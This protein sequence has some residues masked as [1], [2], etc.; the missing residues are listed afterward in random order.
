MAPEQIR[1]ASHVDARVDIWSLGVVLFELITGKL[2]FEGESAPALL[3]AISADAPIPVRRFRPEASRA[4][5]RFIASCLER[6]PSRRPSDIE[7]FAEQ[8]A[9]LRDEPTAGSRP[10]SLVWAAL[11]VGV[12]IAT[13]FA[14]RTTLPRVEHRLATSLSPVSARAAGM[15]LAAPV[16]KATTPVVPPP[17]AV[18]PAVRSVTAPARHSTTKPKPSVSDL[19]VE[20]A[21]SHRK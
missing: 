4:L 16:E 21:T 18:T 15:T 11:L 5:E 10:R 20:A 13:I 9:R 12:A 19:N 1:R 3:A 2:P 7:Q 8:L 6:D 14:V 17:T